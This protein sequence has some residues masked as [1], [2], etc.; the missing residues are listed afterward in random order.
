MNEKFLSNIK[1]LKDLIDIKINEI[2]ENRN[3]LIVDRGTI[4]PMIRTSIVAQ[5]L[6]ERKKLNPIVLSVYKSNSWRYLV[7][8]SFGIKR[9]IQTPRLKFSF[10]YPIIFIKSLLIFIKSY[11]IFIFKDF[12][13]LIDNFKIHNIHIGDLIYD[14]YLRHGLKFVSP[15][16]MD[17]RLI[18]LFL[19]AIYKT[20]FIN[21]LIEKKKIGYVVVSTAT[22]VNDSSI[23]LRLAAQKKI[24]ALYVFWF[25]LIFHDSYERTLL[26]RRKIFKSDIEN[27][28]LPDDWLLEFEKYAT[29]RYS[30]R[31]EYRDFLNAYQNKTLMNNEE[32]FKKL[33]ISKGQFS[34]I[35]LLAPH[36]FSDA[37][38]ESFE[39]IFNDYY[40]HFIQTLDFI[41][42]EKELDDVLWVVNPHPSSHVFKEEGF[43]EKIINKIN[44]KNIVMFPQDVNVFSILRIVDTVVTCRGTIGLEFPACFEKKSIIAGEAPYSGFDFIEEPTDKKSYFDAILNIK[45][46]SKLSETE[47]LLA[48]KVFY[49]YECLQ[50]ESFTTSILPINRFLQPDEF[51]EEVIL[52]LEK[53]NF[54]KDQYYLKTAE[55]ISKKS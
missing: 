25:L 21:T 30:G 8:K 36:A 28:D 11:F 6:N 31:I 40:D 18:Y 54:K 44:K 39:M 9:F 47:K 53:S 50:L 23:A 22:Y 2:E 1:K 41:K 20:V 5:I 51:L 7:Y 34:H 32:L 49:F 26:S 33:N 46:I 10:L 37:S 52:K 4:D 45:N 19:L 15:R 24:P 14:S 17:A 43:A 3:L 16:K 27:L 12:R 48:K 35:A 29:S 13:W 55:L 38:H 42:N